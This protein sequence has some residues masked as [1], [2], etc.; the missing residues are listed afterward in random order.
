MYPSRRVV[1]IVDARA[2]RQATGSHSNLDHRQASSVGSRPFGASCILVVRDESHARDPLRGVS[3][4]SSANISVPSRT[5]SMSFPCCGRHASLRRSQGP[6]QW[7]PSW[8]ECS[9][10]S[11]EQITFLP[12]CCCLFSSSQCMRWFHLRDDRRRQCISFATRRDL[13]APAAAW[14][15]EHALSVS[16]AT[17]LF[18]VLATSAPRSLPRSADVLLSDFGNV[19]IRDPAPGPRRCCCTRT[20]AGRPATGC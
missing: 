15:D 13:G 8:N 18:A 14:C 2:D 10:S 9:E 4:S 3:V 5:T 11:S 20:R 6:E 12:I 16:A 19:Q 1:V 7:R 17:L